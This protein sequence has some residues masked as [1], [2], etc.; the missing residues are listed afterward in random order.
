MTNLK[1]NIS[2]ALGA[3]FAWYD[4]IIFNI[5]IALVF[6]KIFFTGMGFLIP[7]LVFAV[8]FF[9]RPLGGLVYG[10]IGDMFGRKTALVST[11]YLTGISTVLIGL[12]PTYDQIGAS[13][14]I[15]LIAL[16]VVQ[17]VA[18]GGE[19]AAASTMLVESNANSPNK[20]LISSLVSSGWAVASIMASLVFMLVTSQGD[21]FFMEYGWR[22]P[23]LLSGILLV[24]GVY[25]RQRVIESSTFLD[26]NGN[27]K[28]K[29][30]PLKTLISEH[31]KSM[32]YGILTMQLSASWTYIVTVFG[33][34][35]MI[36]QGFISRAGI[37][38]IQFAM[39]W[40]FLVTLLFFGWIGDKIGQQKLFLISAVSSLVLAFPVFYFISNGYAL[41]AMS[42]LVVLMCPA[43][44]AAPKL[45]TSIFPTQVRTIGSGLTYNLGLVVGG[46]AVPLLAQYILS[47][48]GNLMLL[49]YL[50][51]VLSVIA[52]YAT[53]Q[54]KKEYQQ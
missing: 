9:A 36:Q 48:T 44:A 30:R 54:I 49:G 40:V 26:F 14:A 3:T 34:A 19:W 11:L 6:P 53:T 39:A 31:H 51:T 22:I 27:L 37:T 46:G 43:F 45:L 47:A 42:S 24:I 4:F 10:F 1:I 28:E 5:A 17:T 50:F 41:L 52:I 7:I 35:Y 25:I 38:E 15:L 12:L 23:F 8:G 21:K 13:A 20:G 18:F 32:I 33:V 29:N 16:R 2:T